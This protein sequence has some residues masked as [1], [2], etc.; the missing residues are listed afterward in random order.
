MDLYADWFLHAFVKKE[1][2]LLRSLLFLLR[3]LRERLAAEDGEDVELAVV[4][5]AVRVL[6]RLH[7]L[8]RD[9]EVHGG[10]AC[11]VVGVGRLRQRDRAELD[12]IADAQLRGVDAV[13]FRHLRDGGVL[14]RLAMGDGGVG[15]HLDAL[16][17]A[18]VEQREVGVAD[19]QQDLVDHRLY[20]AVRE[21][22]F[23][24]VAQKVRHADDLDLAL[25]LRI[26]E[27]APD[28][29]I[30]FRIA[31]FHAKLVPRLGRVDDH[32]VKVVKA[33]LL[34]R[35]VDGLF[36]LVIG[37]ELRG[38]LAG[39]KKLIARNAAGAHALAH[40]ALVAVGLRGIDEAVA[41][42]HGD[43]DGLGGLI[44]VDE[45]GAKAELGNA[46][47]VFERISFV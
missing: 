7:V 28:G 39:D 15:L 20:A 37:L 16:L 38:H 6:E 13:L 44:V 22:I 34:E 33:H 27:R 24:V 43:A 29:F 26:L 32:L 46:Q 1:R 18:V 14:E 5:D 12:D 2:T 30:F 9:G 4:G 47:A 45:P 3:S 36:G 10:V 11:H 17:A 21:Q 23:K 35:F 31:L 40:A 25:A 42:L 41:E 8:T 19:V